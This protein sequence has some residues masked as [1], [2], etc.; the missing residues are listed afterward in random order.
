MKTPLNDRERELAEQ[1]AQLIEKYL[2][3][4]HLPMGDFYG[5]AA[6]GFLQAAHAYSSREELQAATTFGAVA[7][8]RMKDKVGA[9]FAKERRRSKIAPMSPLREA[10]MAQ[11]CS[12]LRALESR[13]TYDMI[14]DSIAQ[15]LTPRQSDLIRQLAD[16][17]NER[18]LS[19]EHGLTLAQV[20][21]ELAAARA[22][23]VP[24]KNELLAMAA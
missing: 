24:H 18:E 20:R 12:G 16:G 7:T 11:E 14:C 2:G 5:L 9:H 15:V 22:A 3:R 4:R 19:R 10:D 23:L 1:E 8:M 17:A 21:E 6:E 13:E